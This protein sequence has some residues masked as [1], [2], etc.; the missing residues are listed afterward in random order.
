L[1]YFGELSG[2]TAIRGGSMSIT[3]PVLP[4]TFGNIAG[5]CVSRYGYIFQMFLPS[6]AGAAV[7]ED[8]TGGDITNDNG[9]DSGQA[10]V[11][12][13]CYAWPAFAGKGGNRAFFINQ[14]GDVLGSRNNA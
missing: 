10:E 7:A 12:W 3:P 2:R 8:G 5:A 1:G 4:T 14:S 13:C 11:L 6:K 9:V